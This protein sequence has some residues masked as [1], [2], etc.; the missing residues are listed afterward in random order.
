MWFITSLCRVSLCDGMKCN[1]SKLNMFSLDLSQYISSPPLLEP[2]R[3][4]DAYSRYS[5]VIWSSGIYRCI[6]TEGFGILRK[7]GLELRSDYLTFR[8]TVS[9]TGSF[10]SFVYPGAGIFTPNAQL[11][12]CSG[13][14]EPSCF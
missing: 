14:K 6:P 4:T 12:E 7:Q 8:I 1:G 2:P 10:H 5:S 3:G 11:I 13:K 9:N